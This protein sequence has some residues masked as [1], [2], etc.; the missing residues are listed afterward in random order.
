MK[1]NTDEHKKEGQS[2]GGF[3]PDVDMLL[4][5]DLEDALDQDEG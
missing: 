5:V 1:W 2:I 4:V 3:W